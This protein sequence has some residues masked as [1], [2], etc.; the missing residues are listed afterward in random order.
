MAY[1]G[2]EV[3]FDQCVADEYE[4]ISVLLAMIQAAFDTLRVI[5]EYFPYLL[6]SVL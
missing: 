4:S 2:S 3:K 6:T 5:V 1:E